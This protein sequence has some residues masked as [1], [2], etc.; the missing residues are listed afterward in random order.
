MCGWTQAAAAISI[1]S[2]VMNYQNQKN[3]AEQH[4]ADNRVAEGHYN[5]AYL[6]DLSKI[7]NEAGLSLIHI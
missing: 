5:E 6:Y 4:A 2:T 1:A 7:D 3:V